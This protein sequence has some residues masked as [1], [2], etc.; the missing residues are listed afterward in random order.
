MTSFCSYH[1]PIRGNTYSLLRNTKSDMI[2]ESAEWYVSKSVLGE[3]RMS[4]AWISIAT[5]SY[6]AS[7]VES[8]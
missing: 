1:S 4:K 6:F 2:P 5:R 8:A 3:Q 7:V